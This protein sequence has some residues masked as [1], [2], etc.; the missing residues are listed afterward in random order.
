MEE[1]L[2]VVTEKKSLK[3]KF[4][5]KMV[6]IIVGA[7]VIILVIVGL[8]ASNQ[9]KK[10][11]ALVYQTEPIQKGDLVALVGAT[12]TVRANQTAYLDWLTTGRIE[13]INYQVGQ[14]V[15]A[16][17]V[18]ASLAQTS[19]PQE[20]VIASSELISA[21]QSL[22]DLKNSESNHST[23]ELTLAQA[24]RD[25][26]TAL[27]NYWQRNKTQGSD[28]LITVNEA[29][30]QIMDN[31]IVDLKNNYDN[32]VELPSND[33]KKALALQNLTQAQIDRDTLK[34][35]LDYY[36]A[37]PSSLDIDL[38]KS[39]LDVAKAT[40]EDA[41]RQY[42][43]VKAGNNPDDVTA[44]LAKVTS[45]QATVSMGS[46]TSPFAGT[47]TELN[48]MVGDLVSVGTNTFRIDDLSRLL[49]DVEVPEVDINSIKVGQTATL[50][51]D[52]IA[53]QVYSAKVIEVARVGD[54]ISG[55]VNFKVTLQ[56]LNPDAQVLPGM[57]AAVNITV[58]QLKDVLIVANRAV[59]T[60]NSQ[61]VIYL[62]RNGVATGATIELGA[63]SDTTSQIL[64]GD[65]KE[66]DLVIMNPPSSLVNIM[67]SQSQSSSQSSSSTST[68]GQ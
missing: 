2:N 46:L 55:V 9:A 54:T 59:R 57:T 24:Q 29:K 35:L 30:L 1:N 31:N 21:Q 66:G 36:K 11:S 22:D 67:R 61:H 7:V 15:T 19:L 25:Y 3:K 5:K 68:S 58:T 12:G 28:N 64:S 20:V 43:L 60:V 13:K 48:S 34:K 6:W 8:V 18:M 16:G 65:V 38:L 42:N 53:N 63:S 40:L 17:E 47:V 37:M 4:N 50:T 51:F 26:N 62:L 10:A 45:L 41:Q 27:G 56:I 49:V 23:A 14:E 39:K 32:M 44:A 52:A 33:S